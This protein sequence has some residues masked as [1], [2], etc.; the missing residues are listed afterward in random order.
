MYLTTKLLLTATHVIVKRE[1]VGENMVLR[2]TP[3]Q[4]YRRETGHHSIVQ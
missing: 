3:G 2:V 1:R 4:R